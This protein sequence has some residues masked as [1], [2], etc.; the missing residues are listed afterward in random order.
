MKFTRRILLASAAV[1][2]TLLAPAY[3]SAADLIAIITPSHDNPFFKA[4]AEGAQKRAE[5]LGYETL[6]LVHDDDP[7]KQNQ[8]FD[9]AIA[10]GAKA[11]ILDNAGADAT[12]APVRRAKEAGIPSFLIDREIK[13]TGI[14]VSQIVSNNYQGAQLGAE[15]FVKL[16]GEEGKYA[17]LLGREADTNAGIRSAGYHDVI[18]QYP[19]LE[20]VAQQSANWSQTEAYEK[21][22]TIL[23]ANPE[24]KGVISGND[25]MAMG[26]WAALKAAGRTDVIVVGFDGSNDVRDSILEGGIKATVLQPAYRQAQIAVEQA[27]QYLKTGSTGQDE[28][29][30][31]D[32]VLINGSNAGNLETFALN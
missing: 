23:Q 2:A 17:E 14:A 27:D 18:D 19:D 28:K 15:E 24:I 32:C 11:I 8:L 26:A 10:R 22:E 5:D 1:A 4:E 3:A 12:V 20:M 6:V 13:E 31:M 25:T 21:M 29:Q 16:M 9:T 7:N 30:L